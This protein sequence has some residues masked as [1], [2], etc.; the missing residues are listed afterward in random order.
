MDMEVEWDGGDFG[1]NE[2]SQPLWT[3]VPL[4]VDTKSA[5]NKV[6]SLRDMWVSRS[7]EFEF[8]TLGRCAYLDGKTD[9]YKNNLEYENNVLVEA[10]PELYIT[11]LDVLSDAF[12][13]KTYLTKDLRVPGFHI[14]VADKRNLGKA[15]K[16]HE[17]YP[18]LTLGLDPIDTF[19]F[20]LAIELPKS[21]AGMDVIDQFH[22]PQHLAYNV[23]DMVIHTG[24]DIHRIAGFKKY[25]KDEYRITMQGHVVRHNGIL[26]VFF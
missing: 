15:G 3:V 24:E 8:Y 11:V 18:H 19:A 25:V 6:L 22:Q 16:W 20:T 4:E 13:E 5:A 21:G 9:A 10:F 14:F 17:D 1:E 26:E 12:A 2:E 23:G 7:D